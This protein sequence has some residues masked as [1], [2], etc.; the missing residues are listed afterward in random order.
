MAAFCGRRCLGTTALVVLLGRWRAVLGAM[1]DTAKEPDVQ[2][3]ARMDHCW[4]DEKIDM[5]PPYAC[6]LQDKPV[7]VSPP[8][9][10]R[11]FNL[12]NDELKIFWDDGSPQGVFSGEVSPGKTHVTTS[13]DGH[14]FNY[15]DPSGNR[16]ARVTVT[17]TKRLWAI[18]KDV[19]P[20]NAA[21]AEGEK[22][23][24]VLKKYS[25]QYYKD[26]G[27]F[28]IG[29]YPPK[30]MV[31]K[32]LKAD[33]VGQRYNISSETGGHWMCSSPDECAENQPLDVEVTVA[34]V[35][36][37]VLL[38]KNFLSAAEMDLVRRIA[39]PKQATVGNGKNAYVSNTRKSDVGWIP[40]EAG[41]MRRINQR[42]ADMFN[43]NPKHLTKGGLA[44]HLQVVHYPLGGQYQ[45]HHDFGNSMYDRM[46]TI[47]HYLDEPEWEGGTSFPLGFDSKG[48]AVNPP[49]GTSVVFYSML[50]DGNKDELSLHSGRSVG[51]GYKFICNQWIHDRSETL[52]A[53]KRRKAEAKRAASD[54]EL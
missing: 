42:T 23:Y 34:S 24:K 38:L 52:E 43:F 54:G 39:K 21:A 3:A 46:I 2:A 31:H 20:K 25:D 35:E 41:W 47:L 1:R 28:Y 27:R 17:K 4:R 12:F 22:N 36:P 15:V 30:K 50:E 32:M 7:H 16:V 14:S 45:P 49:S 8:Q 6:Y 48:L 10:I 11:V 37:K 5:L 19:Q 44:E 13:Y 18:G 40:W 26:T 33:F 29:R 51:R 9:Y 53:I